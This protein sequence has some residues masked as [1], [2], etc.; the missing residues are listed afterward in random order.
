MYLWL[1]GQNDGDC[2]RLE[3]IVEISQSPGRARLGRREDK[4]P[5]SY[6]ADISL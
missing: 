5:V 3:V 4:T 6:F 1:A 2:H